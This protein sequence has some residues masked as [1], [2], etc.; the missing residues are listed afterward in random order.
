MERAADMTRPRM[1][2][3]R[4]VLSGPSVKPAEITFSKGLNAVVGASDT[5]KTFIAECIDFMLGGSTP[6]RE[7]P[8]ALRYDSARLHISLNTSE[9]EI[10]IERSLR[11]GDFKLMEGNALPI[12]LRAKHDPKKEDSLSVYLLKSINLWGKRI[13]QNSRGVT[14][15][16]SFRDLMRF[17]F[18]DE[19]FI[20]TR[21]SPIHGLKSHYPVA[22]SSVFRLLLTGVD[23]SSVIAVEDGKTV[24]ARASGKVE[25]L[26]EMLSDLD[27]EL[28][29]DGKLLSRKELGAQ[30]EKLDVTIA[31]LSQ[32]VDVDE[33]TASSIEES[34]QE[35]W[36]RLRHT[37]SKLSVQTELKGRFDLLESQYR[38]DL[39]RLDSISE[40]GLMLNQLQAEKC[41][42]CGAAP[43]YHQIHSG[44]P[45]EMT[46]A[47]HAEAAKI[48]VL[49][50]DLSDTVHSN[51]AEVATLVGLKDRL[52]EEFDATTNEI[53]RTLKTR[54]AN[55]FDTLYRA[56]GER[57]KVLRTLEQ[58]TKRDNIYE[59]LS[60]ANKEKPA[61]A[62]EVLTVESSATE[63][64]SQEVQS[65]LQSW[66]YPG[67]Q[68]V[69][70][71]DRDEDLIIS[72][73]RRSSHGKGVRAI[74]HA[75]FNLALMRYCIQH[76]TPHPGFI[77]LDSPLVVYRQ[78]DP[79]EEG[80]SKDVKQ[81]FYRSLAN[82]FNDCQVIIMEN[83]MPPSDL[84][85]ANVQTFT[86][87]PEGRKGFLH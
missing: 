82:N 72:G 34:R 47:C 44:S 3:T 57:T 15:P 67:L 7:I 84:T 64:F 22:E 2:L 53:E 28:I 24:K 69:T 70:F 55:T 11:G 42:M 68:R 25:V 85:G 75:A 66:Q 54:I 6:L 71:S 74:T 45:E 46:M 48:R 20:Q 17:S 32:L 63:I 4:L 60:M 37:D 79:G 36:V 56:K 58:L 29:V 33:K 80:F 9:S 51:N 77:V 35:T 52:Q 41:P 21:T 12:K 13:R 31:H 1:W 19:G 76:G 65:L 73:K 5:G 16:I 39:A 27:K 59:R 10:V 30:L 86:G 83:D 8:E 14:R 38:S 78:P 26:K 62:T 50:K 43:E 87:T 40:A 23:D 49:L 81:N 61:R 18:V